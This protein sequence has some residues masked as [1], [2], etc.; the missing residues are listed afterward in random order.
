MLNKDRLKELYFSLATQ[1]YITARFAAISMLLPVCGN[2]FHHA[3][4]MYLKGNLSIKLSE[5]EL[6]ALNHNLKK[7]WELFKTEVHDPTLSNFDNTIVT[8]DKFEDIRYPD[9]IHSKGAIIFVDMGK[10][11]SYLLPKR[12]E[13]EYRINVWRIDALVKILFA[14]AG[15]NPQFF[16]SSLNKNASKYLRELNQ[17]KVWL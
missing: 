10:G 14:K 7:S 2:L 16:M 4:E 8:L 5:D 1:Y 3:I 12:P 9:K 6:K 15:F 13:I 11:K 17:E